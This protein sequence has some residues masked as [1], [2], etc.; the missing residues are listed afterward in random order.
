MIDRII[1]ITTAIA[2]IDMHNICFPYY[3]KFLGDSYDI[4]WFINIDKPSYCKDSQDDVEKNFRKLL[5]E[6]DLFI[7]KS[8]NPNFFNAVKTL[9]V[10]SKDYLTEN[11]CVL[12]LEDDW[13]TNKKCNMK[14]F[15]NDFVK[16]FSFISLVYNMLG[17]FPPFIMGSQLAKIFYDEYIVRDLPLENPESV[18]RSILRAI[19]KNNG[20]VYYNYFDNAN[21]LAKVGDPVTSGILYKETYLQI[22][23]CRI[24][25][26]SKQDKSFVIFKENIVVP[27]E[28]A[29]EYANNNH[30]SKIVFLRF[31]TK[32]SNTK[33]RHSFF[34]DLGRQWK[35]NI[36]KKIIQV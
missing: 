31:G 30:N 26:K 24:L 35:R 7:Y 2:R 20:I 21:L 17:S 9:L 3:K 10:A 8:V 12:W 6:Y 16:P 22:Q 25:M 28:T 36:T 1:I 32:Q 5:M 23:D 13:I 19:A 4:K 11:C 15:V 18:S 34:K 33:Y 14:Y 27:I 29:N